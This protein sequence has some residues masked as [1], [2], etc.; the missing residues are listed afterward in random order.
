VA[1]SGGGRRELQFQRAR[2]GAGRQASARAR[3]DP[4]EEVL[5]VGQLRERAGSG[6]H[7]CG[8]HG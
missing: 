7:L 5:S 2:G 1:P 8:G 6:A 4:R 3:V